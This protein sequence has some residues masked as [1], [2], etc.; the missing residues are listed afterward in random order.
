M[1]TY[2]KIF[3]KL[4]TNLKQELKVKHFIVFSWDLSTDECFLYFIILLT[5]FP[6][7]S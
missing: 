4:I 5:V 1:Y 6:R 7:G 2:D 3:R